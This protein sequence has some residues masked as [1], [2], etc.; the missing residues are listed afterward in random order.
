MSSDIDILIADLKQIT[1]V[2]DVLYF[3]L[4]LL[5]NALILLKLRAAVRQLDRYSIFT[6][7]AF[8][9]QMLARMVENFLAHAF[10]PMFLIRGW[11]SG[12]CWMLLT[13]FTFEMLIVRLK[14]EWLQEPE[15]TIGKLVWARRLRYLA[16]LIIVLFESTV[17]TRY[18]IGTLY[19]DVLEQ[20]FDLLTNLLSVMTV[21]RT[22]L[23]VCLYSLLIALFVF[24]IRKKKQALEEK[25]WTFTC[26][27][28]F[29]IVWT[30][31]LI[32]QNA[33]YRVMLATQFL[34]MAF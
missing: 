12:F 30:S 11:T 21:I 25:H 9:L 31:S 23:D 3:T 29:I 5:V 15:K 26:F 10:L 28:R 32:L 8:Q 2:L 24:F 4:Y 7:V 1:R 20:N 17:S 6:M 34:V 19:P 18:I 27:N 16:I 13:F 22:L 33:L 14:L